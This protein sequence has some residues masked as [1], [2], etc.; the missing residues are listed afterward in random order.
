MRLVVIKLLSLRK[1]FGQLRQSEEKQTK[2]AFKES[3]VLVL[4]KTPGVPR[5]N[6]KKNA[7]IPTASFHSV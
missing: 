3:G 6:T 7:S 5:Y 2:N 4:L 1:S